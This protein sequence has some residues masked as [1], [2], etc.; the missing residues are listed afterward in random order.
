M[1]LNVNKVELLTEKTGLVWGSTF[2][3]IK[4]QIT[5]FFKRR[6]TNKKNMVPELEQY[7]LKKRKIR[8][9]ED[10]INKSAFLVMPKKYKNDKDNKKTNR[11]SN[12]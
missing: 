3:K 4:N 12:I 11:K 9:N 1:L 5:N 6:L 10:R 8:L 7:D 2:L